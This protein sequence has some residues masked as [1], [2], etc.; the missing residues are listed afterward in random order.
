MDGYNK[1]G[2]NKKTSTATSLHSLWKKHF[3]RRRAGISG[4]Y[5]LA[6]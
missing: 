3:T 6:W 4:I 1:Y 5:F 2:I